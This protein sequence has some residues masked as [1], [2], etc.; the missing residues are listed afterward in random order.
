ALQTLSARTRYIR[1]SLP[2]TAD[3]VAERG[4]LHLYGVMTEKDLK[5]ELELAGKAWAADSTDANWLRFETLKNLV[6]EA[7]TQRQDLGLVDEAAQDS[8]KRFSL[9]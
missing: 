2:T 7:E 4:M 5:H 9:S 8:R 6:S 3:D 1:F